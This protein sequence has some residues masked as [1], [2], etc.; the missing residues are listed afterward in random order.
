MPVA[1]AEVLIRETIHRLG[2]A[3]EPSVFCL[4]KVGPIGDLLRSEGVLV[5]CLNR[6]PGWDFS[7][8]WRLAKRYRERRIEVIHAHQYTP[9]F[10]AALSRMYGLGRCRLVFTEHG[11]H[12]PDVVS[13]LRRAANRLM[14][15]HAATSVTACSD[16][17]AL[18]L[19][20]MDG[21]AGSRIDVIRNGIDLSRYPVKE[22]RQPLRL[23][24]GLRPE[25]RY[26][27][28]V[29]R[30]HPV[31]DHA[32]LI[33]AF[34]GLCRAIPDVDLL[35]AG[36]GPLRLDLQRAIDQRGLASRV[37][38]LGIRF[39]VPAL[40][41]AV[42]MFTLTS[43]SEAAS[44]TVIEAMAS[45]KPMV[46]TNVGGNPELVRDG[47]DGL[48]FPRGDAASGAKAM[49][50]LLNDPEFARQLGDSAR[51]R[52]RSCF[53]LDSTVEQYRRIYKRLTGRGGDS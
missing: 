33:D 27:L 51:V 1:G 53:D 13:P 40:L 22:D 46:V 3:I 48:L 30:F 50:R 7:V 18:A 41:T 32:T 29:A 8:A 10:Y 19:C 6:K 44:L 21:F 35:L 43:I 47:V 2:P 52:A 31:K 42:D 49:V 20:R 24:L 16:F 4:D 5:E 25:R 15:Q 37:Q 34:A 14:L 11:R 23:R 36:D 39:D 9:F 45:A 28:C 17:S 38:F 12:F 26:I